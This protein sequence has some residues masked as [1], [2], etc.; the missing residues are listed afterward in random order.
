[1]VNLTAACRKMKLEHYLT[2]HSKKKKKRKEIKLD[3][4]LSEVRQRKIYNI[5]CMWNLLKKRH[6]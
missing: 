1:M 6:K 2:P 3:V 4:D 5:S